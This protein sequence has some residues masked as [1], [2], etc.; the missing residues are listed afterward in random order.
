[1]PLK[2]IA[3]QLPEKKYRTQLIAAILG[4]LISSN[5]FC[6]D[7]NHNGDWD[8][9]GLMDPTIYC[10]ATGEWR[11]L[12]VSTDYEPV[13]MNWGGPGWTAIQSDYDGD[14][15]S[16]FL[17]YHRASGEWAVLLSGSDFADTRI[18]FGG[19]GW[20]VVTGDYDRDGKTDP[21]V[22]NETTGEW[23]ALLSASDY[24]QICLTFGGPGCTAVS[25]DYDGDNYSDPAFYRRSDGQWQVR[26]SSLGYATN[27]YFVDAMGD[28]PLVPIPFDYDGDRI[29][30]PALFAYSCN[31]TIGKQYVFGWYVTHSSPVFRQIE[32]FYHLGREDCQPSN[33]DPTP[34]DYDGD[35]LGDYAVTWPNT[36]QWRMWRSSRGW[37]LDHCT[38][39]WHITGFR[40]VQR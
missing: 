2:A 12:L 33:A 18:S 26:L 38:D 32:P 7:I 29:T 1:M 27:N 28:G 30:D 24:R 3:K 39:D 5:G 10:E 16:D 8:A 17:A 31:S 35:R 19:A 25:G 4:A 23:R 21:T 9:D 22:Y 37:E 11:A 40:P 15:K 13:W 14:G 34:G 20:G 6:V 36:S